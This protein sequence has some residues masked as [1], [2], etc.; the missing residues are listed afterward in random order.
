MVRL[1]FCFALAITLI[2]TL[3]SWQLWA[4]NQVRQPSTAVRMLDATTKVAASDPTDRGAT[5]YWLEGQASRVTTRFADAVAVTERDA[6]G[7]LNTRLTDLQGNDLAT[8][9]LDRVDGSQHAVEFRMTGAKS[10]R[11]EGRPDVRPT[12]DWGNRQAY[13][14]WKD[15][16]NMDG[17]RLEW[18]DGLMR[19]SGAPPRQLD[20][21]ILEIRTDWPAGKSATAIK[22]AGARRNNVLTGEPLQGTM[23][24]TRFL[25]DGVEIGSTQWYEQEKVFAWSFPGL[26]AGYVDPARLRNIGGWPFTPDMAWTTVQ[27]YAFQHF[28][29]LVAEQGFVA[30]RRDGWL[31]KTVGFFVPTVS[32]N[33]PGCDGLHWLDRSTFRPCCDVHDRCYEKAGCTSR[34]WWQWWTSWQCTACNAFVVYCFASGG[35]PP[36][37][38][39]P[40]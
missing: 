37:Y 5:Y 25:R 1:V 40:Y 26:T 33:E 17:S 31:Q 4:Q 15:R 29:A 34:S 3:A 36:F 16:Q 20:R 11:A 18:R 21:E 13:S 14:L 35:H 32:A 7:D 27:S 12:L 24:V 39:S 2:A 23:L 8:L 19:R 28:H 22:R 6:G 9:A 38:Q 10:I 30:R